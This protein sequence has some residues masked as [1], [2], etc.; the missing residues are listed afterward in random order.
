MLSMLASKGCAWLL[1]TSQKMEL[2][3]DAK[4]VRAY[5]DELE[6]LKV[7]SAKVERLEAD[8]T[9]YRQKAEDVEYLKKRVVVSCDY[10]TSAFPC[11]FERV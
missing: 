6:T 7:Q 2:I 10:L 11:C 8:I 3:E 9:K 1:F 5:R 4:S